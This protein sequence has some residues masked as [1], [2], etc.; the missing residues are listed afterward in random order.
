MLSVDFG[1]GSESA[2]WRFSF[3]W[4]GVF[5]LLLE[6]FLEG[7]VRVRCACSSLVWHVVEVWFSRLWDSTY[8]MGSY[9]I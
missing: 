4:G 3:V 7:G 1:T 9:K 8:V 5:P 2:V 6:A